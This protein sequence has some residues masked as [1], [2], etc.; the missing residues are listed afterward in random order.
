MAA[1][2][3]ETIFTWY[4][5]FNGYFTTPNFTVHKDFKKQPGGGEADLLAVRFPHSNEEPRN[6]P[7]FRD[8]KLILKDKVD[9]VIAEIKSSKCC[10]NPAWLNKDYRNVQYAIKWMGFLSDDKLIEI[11][12]EKIYKTGIWISED[13]GWIIR[14]LSCGNDVDETLKNE[15]PNILQIELQCAIR[16]LYD[17][18][19]TGCNQ[20]NRVHWDQVIRDF[21]E[22]C[23]HEHNFWKLKEWVLDQNVSESTKK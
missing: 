8:D 22:L 12:A 7:F 17:R 19:N 11:A 20:I 14:M 15:K 16:F 4:F 1:N 5:R 21:A 2:K 13:K 10:I 3:V 9:F 18:F 6:Y 23:Q